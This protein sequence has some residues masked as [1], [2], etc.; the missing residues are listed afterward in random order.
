MGRN[1]VTKVL[2]ITSYPPPRAGWGMRV[3]FLK[4]E[5]EKNGDVCEVLNIGKGRFL[6][7][8]DFVPCFSGWDYLKKV[9]LYR[10]KG[11]LIH[12]HLNGDS[13]KG[14]ILTLIALLVSFMTF[15]RAVITFHAGP[16][17]LY[18]PQFKAPML[19]PMY[20]LIFALSKYIICNSEPVK[21]KI[22]GYGVNPD[23]I[24]TIQAFSRQYL[25]FEKISLNG[26]YEEIF[27]NHHPVIFTYVYH[28]PEFF[29]EQMV[30]AFHKFKE[31]YPNAYLL[32]VGYEEGSEELKKL[33]SQLGLTDSIYFTGDLDHDT[34][35]TLLEKASFY[36][37]TPVKD[38]V[39]SSVLEALALGTP[40]IASENG[41]RPSGV[42]TYD[43]DNIDDIVE[44]LIY[45]TEKN[46]QIRK[47]LTP[48]EI[49]DTITT[50]VDL[51]KKA[52]NS[53][54]I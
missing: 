36:W 45:I 42:I 6:T 31:Y 30:Q 19:T 2:H 16:V 23:K 17:Q 15:R 12:M 48:P 4:Q 21:E 43:N 33:I 9:V 49:P 47:S 39:C 27:H 13:P 29:R 8:R 1:S 50:E 46:Q 52:Y 3:Y 32:I 35:L 5:M 44:K 18:F 28:R 40:V 34:F 53:S 54:K 51:I 37:R 25:N 38:G 41:T 14:F 26:K 7:G 20:K 10:L 22:V 11:F 24:F